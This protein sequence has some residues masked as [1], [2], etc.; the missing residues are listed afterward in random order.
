MMALGTGLTR[1]ISFATLAVHPQT[2]W[3]WMA[4]SLNPYFEGND[5]GAMIG[6]DAL[7]KQTLDHW[8]F[9]KVHIVPGLNFI[10]FTLQRNES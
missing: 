10:G 9:G 6:D 4:V 3:D 2:S 7:M 1:L 5:A 8:C